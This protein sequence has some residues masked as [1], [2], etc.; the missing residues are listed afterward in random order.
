MLLPPPNKNERKKKRNTVS[1]HLNIAS[2]RCPTFLVLRQLPAD[3]CIHPAPPNHPT[4]A[5]HDPA[6]APS[7]CRQRDQGPM[8][9]STRW[10]ASS[11]GLCL[12]QNRTYKIG[13]GAPGSVRVFQ[14]NQAQEGPPQKKRHSYMGV[15]CREATRHSFTMFSPTTAAE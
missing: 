10:V 9:C 12:K 7:A 1:K 15:V 5:R 4:H 2:T 8:L 3:P 6:A 13:F 11:F 14:K